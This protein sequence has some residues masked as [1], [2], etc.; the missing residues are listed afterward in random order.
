MDLVLAQLEKVAVVPALV[1]SESRFALPLAAALLEGGLPV[2]E[3]TLR[4]PAALE[5]L[6]E[7]ARYSESLL[8]GAGTV[9]NIAQADQAIAAGAKFIVSPGIDA[10]LVRHCQQRQVPIIPGACTPTEIMLAVNL[11]LPCVKFFPSDA[12]GGLPVLKSLHGPFP[13]MRFMPTGGINLESAPHYLAYPPVLSVG[14][15]WMVRQEWL[16]QERYDLIADACAATTA[17]VRQARRVRV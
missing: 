2:A 9:M 4:T 1:L 10:D 17:A 6:E 7:M 11:G 13:Q 12:Y 15:T 5:I 16:Q 14:G 3:V 8:V